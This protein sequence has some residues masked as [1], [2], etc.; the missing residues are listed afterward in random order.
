MTIAPR[1]VER[2]SEPHRELDGHEAARVVDGAV[3]ER[4]RDHARSSGTKI[5]RPS[6]VV[7]AV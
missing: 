1:L 7:S 5:R 4:R 2:R 6:S 3:D